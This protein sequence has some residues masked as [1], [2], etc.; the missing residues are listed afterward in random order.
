[1]LLQYQYQMHMFIKCYELIFYLL[2]AE[3]NN[4]LLLKNHQSCSTS[5]TLFPKANG[6]SFDKHRGNY[7]R[8]R[9]HGGG[10]N[11]QYREDRTHN[12]SE[13]NN[14]P[15]HQKNQNGKGLQNKPSN[16]HVN[17]CYRC[18]MEGHWS[19][20]CHTPKHLIDLYQASIK[21][22]GK[23]IETNFVDHNDLEDPMNYLDLPNGVDMT[24]PDVSDFFED[25][26]EKFD[27]LIGDGSVHTN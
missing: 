21:E 1:M 11:N 13:R 18:G 6:T 27:N 26:D 14:T 7:G 5:S 2:V 25:V 23:G 15:Y 16:G 20:T 12:S 19:R 17:K 8:G 3:Q 9:G 24:H 10:R 22:K 4:E